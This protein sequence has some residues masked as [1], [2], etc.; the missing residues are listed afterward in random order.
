MLEPLKPGDLLNDRYEVVKF[1]GEGGFAKVFEARDK[2]IGR[3]VAI[4][5]LNMT[6]MAL[7]DEHVVERMLLRF[8]QEARL[9]ANL[10]HSNVVNVYDVGRVGGLMN[11]PYM[12]MEL[13]SG[14]DMSDY[15]ASHGSLTPEMVWRLFIPTL[16]ALGQAHEMGVVHKDLKPANLFLNS[17]G[18]RTE[19]LKIV[20]FGI[21]HIR[22]PIPG[23]D[24][25]GRMTQTGQLLGTPQYL[26][27]E[28]INNQEVSAAMDVYQMTLIL[29]ELLIGEEVVSAQNSIQC[30]MI[31]SDGRL[32]LPNYLLDSPLGPVLRK[33]LALT[34]NDRY[35]NADELADALKAIDPATI[36]PSPKQHN[37]TVHRR[38]LSAPSMQAPAPTH[39][40]S[41]PAPDSTQAS[42]PLIFAGVVVLL[43]CVIGVAVAL[44]LGTMMD[45]DPSPEEVAEVAQ[46]TME[47]IS[48]KLDAP[49]EPKVLEHATTPVE[50]NPQETKPPK[51]EADV[52]DVEPS[53]TPKVVRKHVSPPKPRKPPVVQKPKDRSPE[54][55][56]L[57]AFTQEEIL[58]ARAKKLVRKDPDQ[59]IKYCK[60]I[61]A[62]RPVSDC[63]NI[64]MR[65]SW[66]PGKA[67][68]PRE[69]RGCD[70]LNK[71]MK[72][73]P[74]Y[75][76][77][78][79][80][81]RTFLNCIENGH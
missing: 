35:R 56:T 48:S 58:L 8:E 3:P 50:P 45:Q 33:G 10:S 15:L 38:P 47:S 36:P 42:L 28:Y 46:H 34:P 70:L 27:P 60:T 79:K 61:L 49:P 24:D 32:E 55:E 39:H 6:H 53:A 68:G 22:N 63:Y 29:A 37:Q 75:A 23:E 52:P 80:I 72:S 30:L 77:S 14:L 9:A 66:R 17:P 54:A 11:H 65:A 78:I 44:V 25:G 5:V 73:T 12:V 2:S 18:Q 7:N 19:A 57:D 1:I 40:P 64:I 69:K 41:A 4:K 74:R 26:P 51:P 62:N 13:L 43:L 16:D 76:M 81:Q 21:A 59:A 71:H 20:D 31:H 67:F